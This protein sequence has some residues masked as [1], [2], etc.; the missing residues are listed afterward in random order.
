MKRIPED[1]V[2]CLSFINTQLRDF[3]NDLHDLCS[4]LQI[5]RQELID[6]LGAAGYCYKA[7]LNQFR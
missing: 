7:E 2:I 3:Y 1:P 6:K 4:A 5:D